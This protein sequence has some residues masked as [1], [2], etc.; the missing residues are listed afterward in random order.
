MEELKLEE[1]SVEIMPEDKADKVSPV[2]SDAPK[3]EES[4]KE[5]MSSG[6]KP[7]KPEAAAEVNTT[8]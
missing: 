8:G 6:E 1:V 4:N 5:N 3:Q 2:K 7:E